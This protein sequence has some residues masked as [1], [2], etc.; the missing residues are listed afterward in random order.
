MISPTSPTNRRIDMG[1][2]CGKAEG[3]P[4]ANPGRVLG[5]A[6]PQPKTAPVPAKRTVGGPP[7]Q[8]GGSSGEATASGGDSEARRRAAEAAEVIPIRQTTVWNFL[9]QTPIGKSKRQAH[10]KVGRPIASAKETDQDG[11]TEGSQCGHGT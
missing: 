7:R 3:D 8:L 4:F 1:N 6:P 5:T 9:T 11:Y 2:C 10:G